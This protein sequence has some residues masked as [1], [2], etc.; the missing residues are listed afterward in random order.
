MGPE[1]LE[2][3]NKLSNFVNSK[4]CISVSGRCSFNFFNGLK[5]KKMMK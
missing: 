1:I 5:Y 2:L 3:E 4:Y